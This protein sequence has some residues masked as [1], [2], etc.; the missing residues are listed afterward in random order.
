MRRSILPTIAHRLAIL[1]Y[2]LFALFPLFWLLK[3]FR[4]SAKCPATVLS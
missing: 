3:Y 1:C 4:I 2:V